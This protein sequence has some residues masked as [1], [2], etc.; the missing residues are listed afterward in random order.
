MNCAGS[1]RRQVPSG[2]Q[3]LT[4]RTPEPADHQPAEISPARLAS[5]FEGCIARLESAGLVKRLKFGDYVL[6][7][8]ELLDAYAGAMVNAAR[9][10]PDGLGSILETKVVNV[11]F[12]FPAS[13]R[14]RDQLQERLLVLATLEELLLHELV[15]REPTKDGVQLVFPSAYRRDLPASEMP[16]GDGVVFRFEGPVANIYATLIVRLARSDRFRRV[17][18]WQSAARFAAEKGTCTVALQF[19]VE[20]KAELLIGYDQVP[21]DCGSS[22]SASCTRTS[23]AG[24]RREPSSGSA[25]TAAPGMALA[26]TSGDGPIRSSPRPADILCPVCERPGP[27]RDDY[28]P[29]TAP[30]SPPRRWMPRPTPAGRSRAASAVLRG[31]EEVAEYDVFLCHNWRGQGP[32]SARSPGSFGT[33]GCARGWTSAAP[34]GTSLAAGARGNHRE[35][36]GSGG[37]RRL[38]GGPLA[39]SGTRRVLQ[40]SSAGLRH[41]PGAAAWG[42]HRRPADLPQGLDLG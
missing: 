42:R 10:E 22:S 7:Q 38:P 13:E 35:H 24:P 40:Q 21:D 8:P 39:G 16:K 36:P 15:L 19:E 6:L 14:V 20:G 2:L 41:R 4:G 11:D 33:A 1:F 34:P 18:T 17:D 29:A 9:D 27:L 3:L 25:S 37:D 31:K 23:S 12:P 28:E 30:I 32:P 26:F 5:V